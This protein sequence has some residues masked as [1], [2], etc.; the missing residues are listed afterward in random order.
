[1]GELDHNAGKAGLE[2]RLSGLFASLGAEFSPLDLITKAAAGEAYEAAT[3]SA[4]IALLPS[5]G[6]PNPAQFLLPWNGFRMFRAATPIAAPFGFRASLPKAGFKI[7]RENILFIERQLLAVA[8]RIDRIVPKGKEGRTKFLSAQ[9][10][11]KV[12]GV[13]LMFNGL[14]IIPPIP[15]KNVVQSINA[16]L[17]LAALAKENDVMLLVSVV[18]SVAL[19]AMWWAIG[20]AVVGMALGAAASTLSPL[21]AGAAAF[22]VAKPLLTIAATSTGLLAA[23][24]LLPPVRQKLAQI[25]QNK[26]KL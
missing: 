5:P 2:Q 16:L 17:T 25:I 14:G 9:M 21:M 10:R 12:A 26:P 11:S 24:M 1:M 7:K 19:C 23:T 6:F 3:I 8:R 22:A 20:A 4:F 18:A 13:G 15:L